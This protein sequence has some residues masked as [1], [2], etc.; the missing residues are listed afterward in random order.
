MIKT[1]VN[2]V[3]FH[4]SKIHPVDYSEEAYKTA[5]IYQFLYEH[6]IERYSSTPKSPDFFKTVL[7]NLHYP[8]IKTNNSII[9]N[10][11]MFHRAFKSFREVYKVGRGCVYLFDSPIKSEVLGFLTGIIYWCFNRG[12][13]MPSLV[14]LNELREKLETTIY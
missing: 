9:R 8:D 2:Y 11:L 13:D 1:I 10:H 3:N 7:Y 4:Y 6:Y 14:L 5:L 12:P